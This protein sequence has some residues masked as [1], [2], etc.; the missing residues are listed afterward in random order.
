M[1]QFEEDNVT[2][3][4]ELIHLLGG[5]STEIG[6]ESIEGMILRV[7]ATKTI[8]SFL[9]YKDMAPKS[10]WVT[11][12]TGEAF[13]FNRATIERF[14]RLRL[15]L[16]GPRP[17]GATKDGIAWGSKENPYQFQFFD[18]EKSAFEVLHDIILFKSLPIEFKSAFLPDYDKLTN[19]LCIDEVG[20]PIYYKLT[21]EFRETIEVIMQSDKTYRAGPQHKDAVPNENQV[22]LDPYNIYKPMTAAT[23]PENTVAVKTVEFNG[24]V[25]DQ[26]WGNKGVWVA[27]YVRDKTDG[28]YDT[29]VSVDRDKVRNGNYTVKFD[30]GALHIHKLPC[31]G[32]D[33][34]CILVCPGWQGFDSNCCKPEVKI[35][36]YTNQYKKKKEILDL[37]SPSPFV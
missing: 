24:I 32:A 9:N 21:G 8:Q 26:G 35:T 1:K 30:E 5:I 4:Q 23:I 6:V 10:I 22:E 18:I 27:L 15:D 16:P 29:L 3:A 7:G 2:Q 19:Y 25:K 20:F 36:C 12:G 34:E 31:S 33:V 11:F 37:L 13:S 28:Y 14:R 17:L